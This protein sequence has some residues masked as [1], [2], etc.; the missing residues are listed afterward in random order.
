M[1]ILLPLALV[2]APTIASASCTGAEGAD[3]CNMARMAGETLVPTLP[4]ELVPG[5]MLTES[6]I[7]GPR[8]DLMLTV[9]A[10]KQLP[11]EGNLAALI[12]SQDAIK[13]LVAA[14]GTLRFMVGSREVG[15]V[16]TC[17]EF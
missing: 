14:G 1:R 9:A 3:I 8:L 17:P 13:R 6:A 16:T 4:Q 7:E 15:T 11:P 12:C 5:V 10:D 2:L